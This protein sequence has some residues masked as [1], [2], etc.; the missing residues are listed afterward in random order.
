MTK[1]Q[2]AGLFLL[3]LAMGYAWSWALSTVITRT[4]YGG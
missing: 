3:M 4:F 1:K 2:V